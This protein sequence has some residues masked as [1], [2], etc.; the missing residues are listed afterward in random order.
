LPDA[1]TE[2][3]VSAFVDRA[4]IDPSVLRL[5]RDAGQLRCVVDALHR[6]QSLGDLR[7]LARRARELPREE[8]WRADW[9][10]QFISS[11]EKSWW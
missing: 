7:E 3:A 11:K 2:A 6:K 5:A 9:L 1:V 10:R 8:Q 4:R